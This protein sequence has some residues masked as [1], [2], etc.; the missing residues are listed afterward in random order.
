MQFPPHDFHQIFP[1]GHAYTHERIIYDI[2]VFQHQRHFIKSSPL[3][4]SQNQKKKKK[5]KCIQKMY[6]VL[7]AR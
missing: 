2:L 1:A 3:T 4:S 7:N 5:K 6:S